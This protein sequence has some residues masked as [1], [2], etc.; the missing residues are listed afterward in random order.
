MH[1][2]FLR[3]SGLAIPPGA[4]IYAAYLTAK[5]AGPARATLYPAQS[6]TEK[7]LVVITA[8]PASTKGV[9]FPGGHLLDAGLYVALEGQAEGILIIWD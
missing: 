5:I 3:A 4:K 9:Q 2:V 7:P 1:A 6:P 8:P